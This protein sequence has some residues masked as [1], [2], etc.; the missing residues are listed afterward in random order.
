[1]QYWNRTNFRNAKRMAVLTV[2]AVDSIGVQL[3]RM[4]INGTSS[5][6]E[7]PELQRK[8]IERLI[9]ALLDW[10]AANKRDLPWRR[11][12]DPYAVFIS[13]IML[14]QTQVKTVIPY[15]ERRMKRLPTLAAFAR[16]RSS[17][18]LKLWEGL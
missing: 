3:S 10:Y 8:L 18:V 7:K 6:R 17:A 15:F 12:K 14:Q 16:A 13:E 1:M 5:S 9:S 11:T 2:L 4:K